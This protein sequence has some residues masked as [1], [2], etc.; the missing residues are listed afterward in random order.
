MSTPGKLRVHLLVQVPN[1]PIHSGPA[2]GSIPIGTKSRWCAACDPNQMMNQNNLGT[3]EPWAVHC[4][5][6]RQTAAF[7]AIDRPFPDQRSAGVEIDG[8][9]CCG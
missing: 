6:C 8:D 2:K 5:A 9:G 4:D 3:T 1:G 7:Q